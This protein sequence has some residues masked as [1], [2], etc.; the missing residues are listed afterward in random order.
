MIGCLGGLGRSFSKWAVQR[1]ARRLI[2]LSRT[3]AAKPEVQIFLNSLCAQGVDVKVQRG[4][5]LSLQDVKEAV[6]ASDRPIKGVIQGALTLNVRSRGPNPLQ[7]GIR[8]DFRIQDGLFESMTLEK[9]HSTLRPR[10]I[11][12]LNLHEAL[13]DSPLDFFQMWSSWTVMFGTATQSNY[14]ASSAFMDAFARHRQSQNLPATSLALSQVL[15]IGI[16]SYM[17]E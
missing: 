4:D 14:L 12:T 8:T 3:G 16:V 10:V 6:A 1:G 9:F 2:Y 17:P 7:T 5:V 13:K 11:G 15:G